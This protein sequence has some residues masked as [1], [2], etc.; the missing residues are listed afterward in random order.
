VQSQNVLESK[1]GVRG[2]GKVR[3]AFLDK[4]EYCTKALNSLVSLLSFS[5]VTVP[6]K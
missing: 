6:N 4:E 2:S 1:V 3:M 5:C